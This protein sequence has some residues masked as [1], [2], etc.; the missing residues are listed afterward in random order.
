[1]NSKTPNDVVHSSIV[2]TV[3]KLKSLESN[4]DNN[5]TSSDK[6]NNEPSEKVKIEDNLRSSGKELPFIVS[7]KSSN[8][9]NKS[10]GPVKFRRRSTK[11]EQQFSMTVKA[12]NF[13]KKLL[14]EKNIE[15]YK[16]SLIVIIKNDKE[17][18]GQLED[19]SVTNY[20]RFL[21]KYFFEDFFFTTKLEKTILETRND[22]EKK[23]IFFKRELRRV[24][25]EL[26]TELMIMNKMSK[27]EE[28]FTSKEAQLAAFS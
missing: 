6:N 26:H 19:L 7:R 8:T 25:R 16:E 20:S 3:R 18:F 13:V 15:K 11:A 14:D 27:I 24:V 10:L 4:K 22:K 28:L 1:M 2:K 5:S 9:S 12:N 21:S 23:E 17:I